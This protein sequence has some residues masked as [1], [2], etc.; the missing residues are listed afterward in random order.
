MCPLTIIQVPLAY[1]HL[2]PSLPQRTTLG[3]PQPADA[4]PSSL[5]LPLQPPP[6][7]VSSMKLLGTFGL[8]F[9]PASVLFP[10]GLPSF[11]APIFIIFCFRLIQAP[12][13]SP[14]W[15]PMQPTTE[16]LLIKLVQMS[17]PTE[18]GPSCGPAHVMNSI[19]VSLPLWETP[20]QQS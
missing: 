10:P 16:P 13:G 11:K 8:V 18:W 2:R 15:A 7:Q 1:S 9:Q 20:A 6:A 3:L 19:S 5:A 17:G 14:L 12:S 4:S